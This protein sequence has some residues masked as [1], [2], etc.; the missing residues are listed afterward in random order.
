MEATVLKAKNNLSLLLHK[1]EQ[2]EEVVIRR[3]RHGARFRI[4]PIKP[5]ARRTLAPASQWKGR[6]AYTDEAVWESE[7]KGDE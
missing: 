4:V 6:I 1:A 2:G 3:G 7:W 5:R